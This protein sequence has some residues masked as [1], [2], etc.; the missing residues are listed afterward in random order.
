METV[1]LGRSGLKVSRIG[2]GGIPL[3]RPTEAEAIRMIQHGLDLGINFIDTA[4][5]YGEGMSEERIGKAIAG[6][7]DQVIL[8]TKGGALEHIEVSLKRLNTDYLDLWQFHGISR[9]EVFERVIRPGGP[10][11]EVE[12]FREAGKIRHIGVSSHTLEVAREVVTSGLFDTIQLPFNFVAREA[13]EELAPLAGQHNV[14]FI[15]MKPFAGGML[16]TANLALKYLLQY[17]N[18]VPI[19]GVESIEEV[20]ENVGIADGNWELTAQERQEMDDIRSRVGN[21]F[22]R[23]CMYCMPCPQ[24]VMI[25][26]LMTLPALY[27]LWP[28]DYFLSWP[29]V[30]ETVQSAENCIQC[31]ECEEK[32][33]YELP[34]REMIVESVEF[35][36]RVAAEHGAT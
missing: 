15:A 9:L 4:Y 26:P 1:T 27:E 2:M 11:E 36:Q 6:R 24:G 8:A 3:T 19:P 12:R 29:F 28:P 31:G 23:R 7:R 32:C 30:T 20:E 10:L 34:I 16:K 22:C 35:Y 25:Q 13:G 33:P 5:G 14:G 17:D 21:R 18:V